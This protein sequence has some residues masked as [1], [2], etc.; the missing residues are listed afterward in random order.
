[1]LMPVGFGLCDISTAAGAIQGLEP[2]DVN[3]SSLKPTV[4][5]APYNSIQGLFGSDK[6]PGSNW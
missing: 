2:L 3:V 6:K 5:Q 4:L 1:M